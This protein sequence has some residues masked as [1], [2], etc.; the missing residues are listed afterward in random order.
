MTAEISTEEAVIE[1]TIVRTAHTG[2][3]GNGEIFVREVS[4]VIK[5]KTGEHGEGAV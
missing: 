4:D 5:I 1:E 2:H 3:V